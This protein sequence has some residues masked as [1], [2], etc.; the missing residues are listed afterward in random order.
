M[1]LEDIKLGCKYKIN[2]GLERL[3]FDLAVDDGIIITVDG[4]VR[5][6]MYSNGQTQYET[7]VI[8]VRRSD[9]DTKHKA[10]SFDMI[11]AGWVEDMTVKACTCPINVLLTTGCTSGGQ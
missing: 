1:K 3:P 2:K 5:Q 8:L 10:L 7:D 6:A 9:L 4:I 11:P